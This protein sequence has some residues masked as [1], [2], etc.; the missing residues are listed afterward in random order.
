MTH[1]YIKKKQFISLNHSWAKNHQKL[2]NIIVIEE[3]DE[4][5]FWIEFAKDENLINEKDSKELIVEAKELTSIFIA[6]R[7]TA[8]RNQ[9][10]GK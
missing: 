1:T 10:S 4:C 5:I 8:V 7:I 6:S 3:A 9:N 2:K